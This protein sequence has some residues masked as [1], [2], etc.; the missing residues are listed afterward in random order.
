MD[1]NEKIAPQKII[2][3]L[4]VICLMMVVIGVFGY[5]FIFHQREE[6]YNGNEKLEHK[7]K[8]ICKNTSAGTI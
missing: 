1:K 7:G 8:S 4:L 2:I 3:G 5:Y 6:S